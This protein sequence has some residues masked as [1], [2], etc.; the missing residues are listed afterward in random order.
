[1]SMICCG[2]KDSRVPFYRLNH[3]PPWL[4]SLF[5]AIQHLLV[6]ASLLCTCHSL[7]LQSRPLA[8]QDPNRLLASSLFACGIATL[9]QTCL[10]TRLPLV[11]APTFEL[12][13]P[14]LVLSRR[15]DGNEASRNVTQDSLFCR[16]NSCE[17]LQSV[18]QPVMEVSGAL[19]VSGGLQVLFGVTGA[20]GWILQRCGPM[21]LAPTISIIGL[22][23]Y[24]PVAL[25]CSSNWIISL[26]LVL[27]SAFLSQTLRSWYLPTCTWERET[28]IRKRFVPIFRMLS[29]FIPITCI[30]IGTAVLER[31]PNLFPLTIRLGPNS[32][33]PVPS[34]AQSSPAV[35]G[36]GITRT[37]Q[38]F[39]F[40][41]MGSWGW[42]EFSLLTLSVGIAMALTST[43]CSMG[44]YV[45]CARILHCPAVPYHASNRGICMEG[46]GNILSGILGTVCGAGSS[47]PNT[48]MAALTQ[49]GSR[50]SAQF[51]ALLF[52]VF[53]CSPKLCQF[54]TMIPFSVHG[55]IFCLTFS[56]AVGA[57]VS[58]F[59]YVDVDSGR[60]VFIVGV[61]MFMA[62]LVPRKMDEVPGWDSFDLFLLSVLTVP[63]FLGG[64][65]SFILE[66]TVSG[67]LQ[68]RG[69]HSGI[70]LWIPPPGE[71]TPKAHQEDLAKYYGLPP[72]II[73]LLPLVYPFTQL[74]P[75]APANTREHAAGEG[76]NLLTGPAGKD[77]ERG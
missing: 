14:A 75:P 10:G 74:I 41:L 37:D 38:W 70:S 65:F 26:L 33:V 11:Q 48:G 63:T 1:M 73:R 50:H 21:V 35:F 15:P 76:D 16:G 24:K 18:I 27:L 56:V 67:T 12:L 66:N 4:L 77:V 42:P 8:P 23:S 13:I 54:L 69:L 25:Y 22:S 7:L 49:V 32:S 36:K 72:G 52:L 62:L 19:V 31:A 57:G 59:Q 29:L 61:T 39:Q 17:E 3:T 58:F 40:P 60:N 5:F 64:I 53:G 30:L 6:Q 51:S 43:V 44:C 47:I 28:G 46:V 2:T 71:D 45:L 55:G 20:C 34:G 9:L 68:E